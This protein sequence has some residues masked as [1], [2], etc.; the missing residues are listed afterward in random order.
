MTDKSQ[1]FQTQRTVHNNN[2]HN[3]LALLGS[4]ETNQ[5]GM[6]RWLSNEAFHS[7]M[8]ITDT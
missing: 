8:P 4:N 2:M 6:T 1:S 3:E 5:L 7:A